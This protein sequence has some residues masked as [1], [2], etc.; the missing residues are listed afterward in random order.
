MKTENL[1][2]IKIVIVIG[3]STLNT[4]SANSER[5]NKTVPLN[6]QIIGLAIAT[7]F[8]LIFTE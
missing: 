3:S 8:L 4:F 1:N 6:D 2:E 5:R 7:Y